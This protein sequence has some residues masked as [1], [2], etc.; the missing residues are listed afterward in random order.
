MTDETEAKLAIKE[1]L[2]RYS[3]T[4]DRRRWELMEVDGNRAK[5][6]FLT[7]AGYY[8]DELIR[9]DAGWRI[10]ERVRDMTIQIFHGAGPCVGRR[11]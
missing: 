8:H 2:Y 11:A 1:T 3:L 7:N 10:R 6:T 9:T 4:V 5:S